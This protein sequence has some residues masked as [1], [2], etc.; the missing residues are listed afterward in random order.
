MT[1]EI[2]KEDK[3]PTLEEALGETY[4]KMQSE[5]VAEFESKPVEKPDNLAAT[6]KKRDD[7]C[8]T[9]STPFKGFSQF[10][11]RICYTVKLVLLVFVVTEWLNRNDGIC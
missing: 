5:T 3:I 11:Y 2:E 9:H 10:V 7:G 4:D 6:D 1:D 8:G